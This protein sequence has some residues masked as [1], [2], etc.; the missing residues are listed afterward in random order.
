MDNS[1]EQQHQKNGEEYKCRKRK[2]VKALKNDKSS[3]SHN[4][5]TELFKCSVGEKNDMVRKMPKECAE[6]I[7]YVCSL[8][9]KGFK[10]ECTIYHLM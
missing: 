5:T 6:T 1:L 8:H 10:I 9:K 4:V 2:V 7:I 3:A